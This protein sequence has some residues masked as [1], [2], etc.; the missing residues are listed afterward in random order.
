MA[1]G[2][3]VVNVFPAFKKHLPFN[4]RLYGSK[5]AQAAATQVPPAATLV[6]FSLYLVQASRQLYID[7]ARISAV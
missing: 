4:A 3:A 1:P 6:A 7:I 2:F 5:V